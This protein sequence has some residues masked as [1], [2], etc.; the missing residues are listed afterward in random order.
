MQLVPYLS[1]NLVPAY[2]ES[3]ALCG[4]IWVGRNL[5]WFPRHSDVQVLVHRKASGTRLGRN[6]AICLSVCSEQN[7]YL[8]YVSLCPLPVRERGL[9]VYIVYFLCM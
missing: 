8:Y 5:N 6:Q 1:A 3:S 2:P 9:K 7:D 4:A